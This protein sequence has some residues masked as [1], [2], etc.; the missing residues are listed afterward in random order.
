MYRELVC[1]A[2][3]SSEYS[4]SLLGGGRK[5]K[6]QGPL[7]RPVQATFAVKKSPNPLK[8]P[9]V[10]NKEENAAKGVG[11]ERCQVGNTKLTHFSVRNRI[12]HKTRRSSKKMETHH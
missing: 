1:R 10:T 3:G 11:G 9:P 6:A 4:Q 8:F 5:L 7:L 12:K 2:A